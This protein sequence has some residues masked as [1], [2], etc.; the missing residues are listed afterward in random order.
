MSN[1]QWPPKG[2]WRVVWGSGLGSEFCEGAGE[3]SGGAGFSSNEQWPPKGGWGVVR[4][5]RLGSE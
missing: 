3:S 5:I 2:G 1:E 4:G